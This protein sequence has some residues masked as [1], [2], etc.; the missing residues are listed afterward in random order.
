VSARIVVIGGVAAGMSAASQ[1]KRRRPDAEVVVLERGPYVSYGACG[2]PYNIADAERRIEDLVVVTPEQFR[3]ERGIDLRTRH[4]VTALDL[5]A[6]RLR[7][8]DLATDREEELRWDALVIATGASA[9]KLPIPGME[10]PGVFPLR[11]LGDGAAMKRFIEERRPARAAIIGAGYIGMEMA[12][13]LRARQLEVTVLE[14]LEQVVPGFDP[15]IAHL[16]EGELTANGVRVETGIGVDAIERA[17]G[18]F[19]VRTDRGAIA[20]DLVLVSAGIR[21]NVALAKSAGI[22]LGATG[23]IAV[24]ASMRTSAPDVY[25]AGDCAEAM[26]RVLERPV[27]IP[28]GTT[29]NKQGKVA[30]ANAAGGGERF[31]GVVGTAAFKVLGLEVG[32]TG[33]GTSEIERAGL[34]AV[35]ALSTHKSRGHAYPGAKGIT[36]ILFAEK[37]SGRLLGAQMIGGEGVAKRIDVLATA[38]STRMTIEELES[39][40]LA[41]APPFAPVYDPILVAASVAKK[42]LSRGGV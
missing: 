36:T 15:A 26:H 22:R 28:L 41:Y 5:D 10:L 31:A 32:R 7:V 13:S 37:G 42:E 39:L 19:V 30:G 21:P 27:W 11:Q 16:V 20:A 8:R 35:R 14:K 18:G 38:L 2:M 4:E 25:A 29:A 1:A 9:V 33:L 40:D 12:E 6:K 34:Q 23:A 17:D 24:D 3:R